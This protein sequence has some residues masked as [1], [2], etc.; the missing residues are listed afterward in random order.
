VVRGRALDFKLDPQRLLYSLQWLHKGTP[1]D[2]HLQLVRESGEWFASAATSPLGAL[3]RHDLSCAT[4]CWPP[5]HLDHSTY[6]P[7]CGEW[8]EEVE[9]EEVERRRAKSSAPATAGAP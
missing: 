6:F 2:L 7:K 8:T 1:P 9:V 3:N 4:G 5:L